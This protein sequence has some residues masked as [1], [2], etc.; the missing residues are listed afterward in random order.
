MPCFMESVTE[1]PLGS[2]R[3]VYQAWMFQLFPLLS[4]APWASHLSGPHF[5]GCF[6]PECK[7]HCA[8]E[9]V[10]LW[11]CVPQ[12]CLIRV[13]KGQSVLYG[14]AH[15]FLWSAGTS[16]AWLSRALSESLGSRFEGSNPEGL[17]APR[18]LLKPVS[19]DQWCSVFLHIE[20]TWRGLRGPETRV[21]SERSCCNW[22]ALW[23]PCI[24]FSKFPGDPSYIYKIENHCF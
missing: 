7:G 13:L 23:L 1:A 6:Q 17:G 24:D 9:W 22:P 18:V 8:A 12:I 11:L 21:P 10:L 15:F 4:P 16:S 3:A 2:W 19:M 20:I 14:T 5:S